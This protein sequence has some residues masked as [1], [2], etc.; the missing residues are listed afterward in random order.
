MKPRVIMVS[1]LFFPLLGGT[2]QQALA[3]ARLLRKKGF[4]VAVLTR[5]LKGHP[6]YEV[7]DT[8]PVY[9]HI[10]PLPWGK[11]FGLTYFLAVVWF[12]IQHRHT[13]DI[14]HC[15]I[16]QGFHSVAAMLCKNIFHNKVIVKV[17]ATGPLSDFIMMRQVLLGSFFL[18]KIRGADR[19]ITVCRQS[20]QEALRAGMP[21]EALIRIP[22]GVDVQRFLPSVTKAKTDVRIVFVARL[23]VMKG[24]HV[25]LKA[26]SAVREHAGLVSLDIIGDGPERE[27][28]QQQARILGIAADVHFYGEIIEILPY[29]QEATVFV[30][31]SFSEGLSN[32][33]LEAMAC[34]LPIVATRVGGTPDIIQDGVNG[35][36]VEPDHA[37]Q[38]ASAVNRLLHDEDAAMRMGEAARKTVEQNFSMEAVSEKYSGL[39]QE[40]MASE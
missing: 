10:R 39:Y 11:W 12:L 5:S 30:L 38:L 16:L 27:A 26:F 8:V 9:R 3:L 29:L 4:D 31:P 15:H 7:I 35:L 19:I 33:I 22:N 17:A 32:V 2:E 28:L 13:Y 23:D 37:E 40:L 24:T 14:V 36:L 18:K 21:A 6:A 1:S 20:E 25:L 34:G